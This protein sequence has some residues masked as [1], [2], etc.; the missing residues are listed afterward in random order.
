MSNVTRIPNAGA[1]RTTSTPASRTSLLQSGFETLLARANKAPGT[2][3]IA[4]SF[5]AGMSPSNEERTALGETIAA[6]RQ[7]MAVEATENEIKDAIGL[8]TSGLKLSGQVSGHGVGLAYTMVLSEVPSAIL[9]QAVKALL[10]GKAE[11]MDRTFMPS[12][13]DLLAYCE[14]L[15]RDWLAMAT[16]TE[17]LLA[18]PEQPDR[19]EPMS[20]EHCR[21]MREKIAL[22]ARPKRV[23]GGDV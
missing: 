2:A 23:E 6:V 10:T 7:A 13:P 16:M 5:P 11:G 17:R 19:P 14:K 22:L 18:L 4:T 1:V 21:A 20:E 8:L 12:A 9:K 15:Q 3:G